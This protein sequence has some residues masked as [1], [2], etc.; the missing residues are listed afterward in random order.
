MIF[1]VSRYTRPGSPLRGARRARPPP[2]T[3]QLAARA[4]LH[5]GRPGAPLRSLRGGA[6]RRSGRAVPIPPALSPA[7]RRPRAPDASRA[8]R[9]IELLGG[10]QGSPPRPRPRPGQRRGDLGSR[11]SRPF[12][13]A[14][15]A[16]HRPARARHER[17]RERTARA[18]RR[19]GGPRDAARRAR[20]ERTAGAGRQLARRLGGTALRGAASGSHRPA[21]A[22][23][24]RGLSVSHTRALP[25]P[26]PGGG[27]DAD[28]RS[29]RSQDPA[30]PRLRPRRRGREAAGGAVAPDLP[31]LPPRGLPRPP[32]REDSNARGRRLGGGRW[33]LPRGRGA[34]LRPRAAA[35]PLSSDP[36]LRPHAAGR[37]PR[38]LR[39]APPLDPR[40]A[41][42]RADRRRARRALAGS[43]GKAGGLRQWAALREATSRPSI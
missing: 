18:R 35:R 39:E 41:T 31:E 13:E 23:R 17:S 14:P 36:R 8:A 22:A 43:G 4:P 25:G 5:R 7:A 37:M 26:Q 9:D 42:A 21:R 38:A 34:P 32:D 2:Q 28:A 29:R 19:G 24:H 30:V 33:H 10:G 20:Q 15:P 6:L 12:G 3:T 11:G 1:R 16:R 40:R 27:A